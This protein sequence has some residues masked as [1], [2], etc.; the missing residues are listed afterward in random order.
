MKQEL[1]ESMNNIHSLIKS[2]HF[3]EQKYGPGIAIHTCLN[4]EEK[5]GEG[6]RGNA[7]SR[8]GV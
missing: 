1:L 3:H 2:S 5:F 6:L 4:M 7:R 8:F